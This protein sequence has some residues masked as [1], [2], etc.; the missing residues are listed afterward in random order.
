MAATDIVYMNRLLSIWQSPL[1][2]PTL[3]HQAPQ[4]ND[5][6]CPGKGFRNARSMHMQD[7]SLRWCKSSLTAWVCGVS[8]QKRFNHCHT[9]LGIMGGENLHLRKGCIV[10]HAWS[11][12]SHTWTAWKTLHTCWTTCGKNERWC[13]F[14]LALARLIKTGVDPTWVKHKFIYIELFSN[15]ALLDQQHLTNPH[16]GLVWPRVPV[17]RGT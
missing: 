14:L 2:Y 6:K 4:T 13:D 10:W 1:L 12:N 11:G 9:V 5:P 17:E 3:E 16:F 8:S 15:H 7:H